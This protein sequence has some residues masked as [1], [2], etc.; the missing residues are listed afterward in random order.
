MIENER[1]VGALLD[2]IVNDFKRFR[3]Q[4][5]DTSLG[6]MI[7]CETNRQARMMFR[8]YKMGT[9]KDE[10][11]H[12]TYVPKIGT[13]IPE[14]DGTM[15]N[16]DTSG[17]KVELILHDYYDKEKRANISL[18]FRK[19]AEPDLLIVNNML[20][21]GFDAP[22]LKRL[23]LGRKLKDHNLLQALTR[24]NRPYK[25]I[26]F[27]YVVDF[28]DIR[29]NF[30][31]INNAYAAELGKFDTGQSEDAS[32]EHVMVSEEE[33]KETMRDVQEVLF[34][35]TTDNAEEFAQQM[36]DIEDHDKLIIIR[37]K[38]EEA[39]ATWNE[40]RTFG[41]EELK[42]KVKAMQ[43]GNINNLLKVVN[44]RISN[45]NLKD[46]FNH[47]AEVASMVNEALGTIEFKFHK[48]GSGEL[49][50]NDNLKS[51]LQYKKRA[52]S[53]E[54]A[55]NIDQDDDDYVSLLD[56]IKK[57][58]R[59]KGF[60]PSNV[61]EAKEDIGFMDDMMAKIKE[62]NKHNAAL[63]KKYKG[64]AKFVRAHKRIIREQ[65]STG[66]VIISPSEVETCFALNTM[67]DNIDTML[68]NNLD[69]INN[70]PFF[71]DQVKNCI[72]QILHKMEVKATPADRRY[73]AGIITNEYE[74]QYK[75]F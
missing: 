65:K 72:T 59:K 6:G 39:K 43:P 53:D 56:E 63:Q 62:I 45:L 57:Y 35:Y 75:R 24:V 4:M 30:N 42:A 70:V 18:Q 73:L 69:L 36:E 9:H 3:L 21:T 29:Q 34:D 28:A 58:F 2:Y 13:V 48:K 40:V 16:K 33:I 54:L 68:L 74:H 27:G 7:V 1:Y 25:D 60:E 50:I 15:P 46:V 12:Y 37:H 51:E 41:S 31:D 19:K 22:R 14:D 11:G 23:Y 55:E 5:D 17:L 44:D 64:D 52:L 49:V 38:L 61:A 20:L 47:E 8:L 26:R 32:V 10:D 67:K 71:T 66:K